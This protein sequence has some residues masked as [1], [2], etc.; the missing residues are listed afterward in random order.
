MFMVDFHSY[1]LSLP[2][3]SNHC[4]KS[5]RNFFPGHHCGGS[6]I[7]NQY[8]IT[9]AH[10]QSRIN[11]S[12]VLSKVRLGEYDLRTD[13]DCD[14][15][16]ECNDPHVDVPVAEIIMHPEYYQEG[17]AQYHDIALLKLERTVEFTKWIKPICLPLDYRVRSMDFTSHSLEVAGYGLTENR[18]ASPIKKKV[19]LEGRTQ[20]ECQAAYNKAGIRIIKQHVSGLLLNFY[21]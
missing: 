16:E 21:Y 8:V 1:L 13:P 20:A 11:K 17:V 9:A 4:Y 2:Q 7:N 14:E 10:C 12:W 3:W 18:V 19:E 6:L 5:N 15:D